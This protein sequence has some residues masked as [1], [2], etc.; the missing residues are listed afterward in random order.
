MQSIPEDLIEGI[1]SRLPV[2][3]LM[4]FRCVSKSW[5]SLIDHPTFILTHYHLHYSLHKSQA[6]MPLFLWRY[7]TCSFPVNLDDQSICHILHNDLLF[8]MTADLQRDTK[9]ALNYPGV[10]TLES[11]VCLLRVIGISNG[12]VCLNMCCDFQNG[13]NQYGVSWKDCCV[14]WNP[15]TRDIKVIPDTD[16]PDQEKPPRIDPVCFGFDNFTNDFK[17]VVKF[18]THSDGISSPIIFFDES[19]GI[20]VAFEVYSLST[21]SWKRMP[22]FD[23]NIF[24]SQMDACLN[25]VYYWTSN[26][27]NTC[28]PFCI[29]S[30]NFS[31]EVFKVSDPPQCAAPPANSSLSESRQCIGLYKECLALIFMRTTPGEAIAKVDIWVVTKFDDEDFGVPL[32]WQCLLI[33]EPFPTSPLTFCVMTPRMDGQLLLRTSDA[34]PSNNEWSLYDPETRKIKSLGIRWLSNCF[35]YVES[36]FPLSRTTAHT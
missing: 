3:A 22:Y 25:G 5:R 4:R 24:P 16:A 28:L 30:Y 9:L 26:Q 1:L 18:F 21:D 13:L 10:L 12:I 17:V 7:Q 27:T 19:I 20:S 34:D 2:I 14:L 23:A 35:R 29:V 11:R 8:D 32:E 33:I 6:N 15:A 31:T 36:L